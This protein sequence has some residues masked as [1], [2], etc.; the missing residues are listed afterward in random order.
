M[1]ITT[2]AQRVAHVRNELQKANMLISALENS[3]KE[4]NVSYWDQGW[5]QKWDQTWPQAWPQN[6]AI[7]S[8]KRST[9]VKST[10]E[11]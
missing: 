6:G 1:N 9:T 7:L 5:D 11:V 3:Q 10:E 4:H 2:P 8:L